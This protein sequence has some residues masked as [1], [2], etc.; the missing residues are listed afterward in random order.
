MAGDGEVGFKSL[1]GFMQGVLI[2][3]SI[4][5]IVVP[6]VLGFVNLDKRIDI[7]EGKTTAHIAKDERK[8]ES[9]EGD[10]K[11][12]REDLHTVELQLATTEAHYQ[13]IMRT[14]SS[15]EKQLN[16]LERAE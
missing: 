16:N 7:T 6:S 2:L 9:I 13:E 4:L 14:L 11:E 3:L 5:G 15:M 12:T 1:S 8:W 10:M